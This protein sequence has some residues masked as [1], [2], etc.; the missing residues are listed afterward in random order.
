MEFDVVEDGAAVEGFG[1]ELDVSLNG[2][3]DGGGEA[4]AV[5]D[6]ALAEAGFGPDSFDGEAKV[7][8]GALDVDLV[9]AFHE[10]DEGLH[11]ALHFGVVDAGA[12]AEVEVF[13]G[14]GAHAGGLGHGWK[15]PAEDD[16]AGVLDALFEV[17]GLEVELFGEIDILL[18]D[19]RHLCD[20]VGA[21]DT[22]VALD[23]FHALEINLG[24]EVKLIFRRVL[25]ECAADLFV[26]GLGE[27]DAAGFGDG[28]DE[29]G[30]EFGGDVEGFDED[31]VAGFDL[32]G[33]VDEDVGEIGVAWVFHGGSLGG[34][35]ENVKGKT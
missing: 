13:E 32:G 30:G 7:G 22:D 35:D 8:A 27:G 29:G 5:G 34:W 28:F 2:I 10:V 17:D 18:R 31:F 16:P 15:R 24:H 14:F 12:D 21:A 26:V 19:V 4:F 1:V 23:I 6:V 33:V 9:G 20:V 11:G 3:F 25:L